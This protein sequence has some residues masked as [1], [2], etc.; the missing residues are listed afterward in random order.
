M[1][2][3]ILKTSTK[4][5]NNQTLAIG[6]KINGTALKNSNNQEIT[7]SNSETVTTDS[8]GLAN[9]CENT[10]VP[11]P[12]SI[13]SVEGDE[14]YFT[15]KTIPDGYRKL[16]DDKAIKL[17]VIKDAITGK[18]SNLAISIVNTNDKKTVKHGEN[19]IIYQINDY[20]DTVKISAVK[21]SDSI[22]TL[23]VADPE[24]TR[25]GNYNLYLVKK[26][27]KNERLEGVNFEL[28]GAT[29]NNEAISQNNT[30][31]S[32]Q[33]PKAIVTE[34]DRVSVYTNA[35][36]ND[37]NDVIQINNANSDDVFIL[38]EKDLGS[39]KGYTQLPSNYKIKVTV[40]KTEEN[41][42]YFVSGTTLELYNG[43]QKVSPKANTEDEYEINGVT[44]KISLEK[45]GSNITVIVENPKV[46]GEYKLNVIKKDVNN[47]GS[48]SGFD[49]FGTNSVAGAKFN[50]TVYKGT[51]INNYNFN[52]D[53]STNRVKFDEYTTKGTTEDL[54][55]DKFKRTGVTYF[56]VK[57]KMID[58]WNIEE[59]DPPTGFEAMKKSL[60]LGIEKS[61]NETTKQFY[62]DTIHIYQKDNSSIK[63][64]PQSYEEINKAD[65]SVM[66]TYVSSDNDT[67]QIML[68]KDRTQIAV[69]ADNI[70]NGEYKLNVMKKITD[71]NSSGDTADSAKS[72]ASFNIQLY[73][74]IDLNSSDFKFGSD[75]NPN[76]FE[77]F[78]QG[79]NEYISYETKGNAEDL[80]NDKFK[81]TG[82]TTDSVGN[83]YDIWKINEWSAPDGLDTYS[84]QLVLGVKKKYNSDSH[85][86][87]I[88]SITMYKVDGNGIKSSNNVWEAQTVHDVNNSNADSTEM[89]TFCYKK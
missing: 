33:N 6:A 22:I 60:V 82:I 44:Y 50:V 78:T 5:L 75:N 53:S 39:N 21:T 35:K 52:F 87:S 76:N 18:V 54:S 31:I 41:N 88:E 42:N 34:K 8:E 29:V 45:S 64:D 4:I 79:E 32:E 49:S 7:T 74:D 26:D 72:G 24:D 27:N 9:V 48:V 20:G 3:S 71:D 23:T 25:N 56:D 43:D 59:T 51:A 38:R 47:E 10:S 55:H 85:T 19:T 70:P 68:N 61:Y 13:T 36:D 46:E 73:K 2:P 40:K 12:V 15:E 11:N 77:N 1:K 30:T 17:D 89:N 83:K 67:W 58:I 14:Y 16:P 57:N 86:F 69:S 84:G 65:G 37:G 81:R 62:I 80:T 28:I 63:W 66:Y